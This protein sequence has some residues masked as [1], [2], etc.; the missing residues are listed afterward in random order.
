[1]K[2][3]VTMDVYEI[4]GDEQMALNRPSIRVERHWNQTSAVHGKVVIHLPDGP[5]YTVAAKDLR[6]AIQRCTD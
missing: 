6:E 5:S 4:G 3:S 1:M 2:V